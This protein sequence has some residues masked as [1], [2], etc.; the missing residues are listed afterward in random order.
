MPSGDILNKIEIEINATVGPNSIAVIVA[1]FETRVP[2]PASLAL[3][4]LGLAIVA[5]R[6]GRRG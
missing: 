6:R 5:L 1:T 3:V 2:E 4:G